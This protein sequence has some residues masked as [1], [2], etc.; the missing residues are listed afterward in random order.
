[1]TSATKRLADARAAMMLG[2]NRVGLT[3]MTEM[4]HTPIPVPFMPG[5]ETRDKD[6]AF[7][8]Y[9]SN[10]PTAGTMIRTGFPE[11]IIS[12]QDFEPDNLFRVSISR[13]ST[14]ANPE[15]DR[16]CRPRA[17]V[18]ILV[19]YGHPFLDY[20]MPSHIVSQLVASTPDSPVYEKG[21]ARFTEN[22]P[23]RLVDIV[24]GRAIRPTR[25]RPGTQVL[26]LRNN[27]H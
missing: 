7:I 18:Q 11:S 13:E 17:G 14:L 21:H 2:G 22:D 20:Q 8:P 19:V 6:R 24:V 15:A 23:A 1:M 27:P 12:P 10:E 16:P 4:D 26:S 3:H 5:D 9:L 25:I